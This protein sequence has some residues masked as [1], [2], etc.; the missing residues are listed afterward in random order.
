MTGKEIEKVVFRNPD[1]ETFDPEAAIMRHPALANIDVA[2]EH[3]PS[4]DIEFTIRRV[5]G[6][7]PACARFSTPPR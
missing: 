5:L 3:T 4:Y 2:L 6:Q 7:W 1:G